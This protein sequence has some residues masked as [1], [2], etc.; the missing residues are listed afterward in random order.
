MRYWLRGTGIGAGCL[1]LARLI[2]EMIHDGPGN[3]I[4][5]LVEFG[6]GVKLTIVIHRQMIGITGD[7]PLETSW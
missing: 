1:G 4:C 3:A 2:A 7:L 5:H 6:V